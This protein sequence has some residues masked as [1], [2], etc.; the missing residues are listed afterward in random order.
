MHASL[1]EGGHMA[2]I[3]DAE[4]PPRGSDGTGDPAE[5]D[6]KRA[7]VTNDLLEAVLACDWPAGRPRRSLRGAVLSRALPTGVLLIVSKR[8]RHP[9]E[10]LMVEAGG[11]LAD[12]CARHVRGEEALAMVVDAYRQWQPIEGLSAIVSTDIIADSDFDLS[13]ARYVPDRQTR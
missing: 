9:G 3:L 4:L 6:I 13:P 11:L 2:A 1:N 7:F 12:Y 10:V 8:K 5:A